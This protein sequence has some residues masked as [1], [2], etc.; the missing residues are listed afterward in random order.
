MILDSD[1]FQT[2]KKT[3]V[4]FAWGTIVFCIKLEQLSL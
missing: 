3:I 1:E 4:P 2:Y